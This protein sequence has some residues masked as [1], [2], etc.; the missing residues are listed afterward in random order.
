INWLASN[1]NVGEMLYRQLWQYK[2]VEIESCSLVSLV[3]GAPFCVGDV[4]AD[5]LQLNDFMVT[6]QSARH[7]R[8]LEIASLKH[9]HTTVGK[10][11]T[12]TLVLSAILATEATL[13]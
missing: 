7:P 1:F 3:F 5:G 11:D 13:P 2:T 10:V 9:N 6:L 8:F 4:P 12:A